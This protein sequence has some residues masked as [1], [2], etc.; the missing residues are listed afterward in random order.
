MPRAPDPNSRR[1]NH[2]ADWRRLPAA[3]R[4]GEAP[5]WPL[6]RPAKAAA[7]LWTELWK[8]PQAVA[9][10]ELG[11][12]R[13][14]ARYV[15]LVLQAEKSSATGAVLSETRQLED[16]LGLNPMAMRRLYWL[17]EEPS[18]EEVQAGNVADL[19]AYRQLLG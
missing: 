10:E 2:R 16:R 4:Q 13:I 3:G 6:G 12:T 18:E 17:I 11:W 8:T 7:D 14:V 19:T 5:Q 1:R 9:W 15:R